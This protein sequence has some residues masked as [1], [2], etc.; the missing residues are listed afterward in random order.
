[1]IHQPH[2]RRREQR[3]EVEAALAQGLERGALKKA[4]QAR[5]PQTLPR[6]SDSRAG[7][8]AVPFPGRPESRVLTVAHHHGPHAREVGAALLPRRG[9]RL[10]EKCA[11]LTAFLPSLAHILA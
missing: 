6:V 7:G 11:Q 4:Q 2:E 10:R 3:K 8:T 1:M 9:P 5:A